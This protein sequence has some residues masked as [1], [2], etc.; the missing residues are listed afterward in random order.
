[1]SNGQGCTCSAWSANECA[2]GADWTP[3]E[4]YDLRAENNRL[5][6]ELA[7]LTAGVKIQVPSNTM[8]YELSNWHRR[9]YGKAKE[10]MQ[11]EIERLKAE[12][13]SI[14]GALDDPRANLTLTTAEIIW[15]I[16]A[17]LAE[18]KKDAERYR[19][20]IKNAVREKNLGDRY[21]EFHCDFENWNNVT[22]AI[23]AAMKGK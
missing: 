2:C 19:W 13:K 16:K 17:E 20:L 10:E 6:A 5:K 15:G 3:Q 21:I 12:L 1:M 14:D 9:G 4:V 22:E 18:A 8:E 23:D 7:S 11:K